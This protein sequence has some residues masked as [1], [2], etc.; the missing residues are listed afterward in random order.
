MF[1]IEEIVKKIKEKAVFSFDFS[2]KSYLG[3]DIGTSAIKIV[4]ISIRR[5]RKNLENYGEAKSKFLFGKYYR[6]SKGT[7][8]FLSDNEIADAI[9]QIIKEANIKTK[10]ATFALPDFA[11][12]FTRF[13]LPP[14]TKEELPEAV[15]FEARQYIPLP[16]SEVTLDWQILREKVVSGKQK[17]FRILLV[18]VPQRTVQQYQDI[19]NNV[20]LEKFALE[21]EIFALIRSLIKGREEEK[22]NIC[23][24]DIGARTTS[25][26]IIE[27][28]ELFISH[29]LDTFSGN[30]LT[31]QV[32]RSLNVSLE[33]AEELK[34]KFGMV[35]ESQNLRMILQP[36]IDDLVK[37]IEKIISNHEKGDNES[38][39]E[40][41][42]L[43]GGGA[44]LRGL[45]DYLSFE[46]SKE[47][48]IG[49][50]FENIFYPPILEEKI[51]KISSSYSVAIGVAQRKIV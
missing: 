23:L 6:T 43:T 9:K 18:A 22:K 49:N 8:I 20:G 39:I 33:E 26:S 45:K 17:Q 46:I 34:V 16:L 40:E 29:S 51:K 24:V 7:E 35:D 32:S 2:K 31:A 19:A 48:K 38:Q 12:F 36:L 42:I 25:I 5:N 47:T 3:I 28:G 44:Q 30:I 11:S 1:S 21:A 50:P 13:D 41:I 10:E 14:M 37:K 15:R 27:R 4:D